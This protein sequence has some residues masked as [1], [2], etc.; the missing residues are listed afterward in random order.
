MMND[1]R[2]A[3]IR[4][5]IRLMRTRLSEFNV[6]QSAT[7][8]SLAMAED[9]LAAFD[10]AKASL[11]ETK[12]KDRQAAQTLIAEV[13]A[14]GP[15]DVDAAAERAAG[16]IRSLRAAQE[17]S[18][19][20]MHMRIRAGYDRTVADLW[21][22]KV[23]EVEAERDEARAEV[24]RLRRDLARCREA[25]RATAEGWRHEVAE[26][27]SIIGAPAHTAE[28]AACVRAEVERL[29]GEASGALDANN[30]ALDGLQT[31]VEFATSDL[32]RMEAERDCAL[33]AIENVAMLAKRLRKTDPVN[34]EHFL[35]F[36]REAGW[37]DSIL[38][39]GP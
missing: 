33:H 22:K 20:Q 8:L 19:H 14:D 6:T 23:A 4:E 37:E 13:G 25:Q 29:R 11:R 2:E 30:R 7:R 32:K 36:C 16:V 39:D 17:E 35:R 5:T 3:E 21:R 15:T 24:E 38:R 9:I 1:A 34:A 28:L 18:E 27:A 12:E 26:V 10:E 31:M